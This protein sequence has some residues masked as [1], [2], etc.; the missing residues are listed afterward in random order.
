MVEKL[1][2]CLHFPIVICWFA[3]RDAG[4]K[5]MGQIMAEALVSRQCFDCTQDPE[6]HDQFLA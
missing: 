5:T 3:S 4:S 2:V 6:T 1:H